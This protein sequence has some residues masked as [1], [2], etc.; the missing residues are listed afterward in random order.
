MRVVASRKRDTKHI[1]RV[2][3]PELGARDLETALIFALPG[4]E[5]DAIVAGLRRP[6]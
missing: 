4:A 6:D 3:D 5:P 1:A 2:V